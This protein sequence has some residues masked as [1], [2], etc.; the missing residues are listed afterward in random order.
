MYTWYLL[1]DLCDVQQIPFVLGHVL[2]MRAIHGTKTKSD[3][4]DSQKIA[5]LLRAGLVPQA[6]VYPA[7]M[8]A[9]RDLL[10]RRMD[11]M[12][13]RASLF[14]HIRTTNHQY[15]LPVIDKELRPRS[16]RIGLTDRFT[17]PSVKLMIEAD[18]QLAES[19]STLLTTIEAA[20]LDHAATHHNRARYLLQT[21]PGVG[22]ILALVMIY[23]IH[24]IDRFPTVNDF[25]SYAR[26]IR[27]TKTSAGKTCGGGER[28]MGNVY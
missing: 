21:I 22:S 16:N 19:Y 15:N 25:C 20:L 26:L 10:R 4:I 3:K 11:L 14:S 1:A 28:K 7:D 23:E 5:Q 8:R 12:H 18:L 27:V 24:T 6:Y 17:D 9:T 2:Y 13:K